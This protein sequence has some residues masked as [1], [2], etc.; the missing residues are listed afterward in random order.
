MALVEG[1]FRYNYR[2]ITSRNTIEWGQPEK[3]EDGNFS[4]RYKYSASY[5][6]GKPKIVNQIWLQP[7]SRA[8]A[9]CAD[10]PV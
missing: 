8:P 2:D 10:Y 6:G 7:P 4:I 5:W 1:F 9:D 3:T